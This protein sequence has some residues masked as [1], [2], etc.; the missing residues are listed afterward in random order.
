MSSTS[1]PLRVA[2]SGEPTV[3]F[4]GGHP[5]GIRTHE[6]PRCAVCGAAMCHMGQFDSGPWLDLGGYERMTLFICHATGGRCEDWEPEKGANRVVLQRRR[7]DNL[8]DG[9]HTVRVYRRIPLTTGAA[10]TESEA[11]P[12]DDKLGGA[13]AW[14]SHDATPRAES[15]F[16]RLLLQMTTAI[17]S[18][19]ITSTGMAYVFLDPRRP[20]VARMLWQT[21]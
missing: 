6:W 14:L 4:Y 20:G 9:P 11:P 16:M 17:V 5:R 12:A 19:D 21:K 3:G 8:Y 10:V 13:P 18:F 15:G 1:A 7:D 2:E